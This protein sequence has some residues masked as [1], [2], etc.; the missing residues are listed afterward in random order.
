MFSLPNL[1]LRQQRSSRVNH[2]VE[3]APREAA[4]DIPWKDLFEL[5][6]A[7]EE[8]DLDFAF[9]K[10]FSVFALN[11]LAVFIADGQAEVHEVA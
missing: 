11:P 2:N 5:G 7:P 8:I 6:F 1:T 3:L 10:G 4:T 9:D